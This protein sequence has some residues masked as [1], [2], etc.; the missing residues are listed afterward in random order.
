MVAW[1]AGS[2]QKHPKGHSEKDR[3][4][5]GRNGQKG[6]NIGKGNGGRKHRK[7]G[8]AVLVAGK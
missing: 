8:K 3:P 5:H 4:W 6:T 7:V 2:R 1:Q